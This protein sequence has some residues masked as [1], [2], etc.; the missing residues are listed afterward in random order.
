MKSI[1]ILG[2]A[3]VALTL[4]AGATFAIADEPLKSSIQVGERIPG[5]FHPLNINGAKAGEKNCLVCQHGTHPVAMVFARENSPALT[6]LIKSLDETT[7]KNKSCDM[8]SFVVFLSDKE[9]LAKELKTLAEKENIKN[10][11]LSI[12]NPAGPKDYNVTKTADVTVVLYTGHKVMAN[13]AYP[14]GGLNDAAV[15]EVI[16][17]VSKITTK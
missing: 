15:T 5:P 2:I 12:D 3:V 8:G 13:F 16:K 7:A 17:S 1:R 6:K 11:T 10:V 14:K 9:D 4:A